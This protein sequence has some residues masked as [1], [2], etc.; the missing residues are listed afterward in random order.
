MLSPFA[1]CL[2]TFYAF[3]MTIFEK[4]IAREIPSSI[5]FENDDYIAFKDINPRAPVH[6]LCVPKKVS[7]RLDEIT[8]PLETGMLYQTAIQVAREACGLS[9]Y[10]LVVNVGAG[11][12]QIVFHTHIHILGGWTNSE[13]E[14]Q[15]QKMAEP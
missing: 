5:V 10:R 2:P 6:V 3:G 11:A 7:Q 8:D 15:H 1:F 13:A 12:G 14:N 4:I 9:D